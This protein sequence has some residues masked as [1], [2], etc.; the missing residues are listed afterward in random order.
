[1]PLKAVDVRLNAAKVYS[2]TFHSIE[3]EAETLANIQGIIFDCI[4]L[5][6]SDL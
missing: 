1:M 6:F 5:R 4:F 2:N 3:Y